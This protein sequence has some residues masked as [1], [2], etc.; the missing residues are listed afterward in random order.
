M[1]KH[2]QFAGK[3]AALSRAWEMDQ[4]DKSKQ[5]EKPKGPRIGM[6]DGCL[7]EKEVTPLRQ[8]QTDRGDGATSF[9]F[10]TKFFCKDCKPQTTKKPVV[11]DDK[12]IRS[13]LKGARKGLR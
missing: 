6:C 11:P 1:D 4:R 12:Q 5:N 10:T 7:K 9:G 13:M 2:E 3:N 8:P